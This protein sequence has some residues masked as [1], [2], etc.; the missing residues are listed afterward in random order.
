VTANGHSTQLVGP[1]GTVTLD[2]HLAAQ[3]FVTP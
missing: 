3:F 1:T 2:A